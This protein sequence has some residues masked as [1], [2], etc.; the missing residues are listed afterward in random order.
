MIPTLGTGLLYR[1][2]RDKVQMLTAMERRKA[3][4]FCFGIA[5]CVT[6]S[7]LI[8]IIYK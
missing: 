6:V 5:V 1:V 8:W 7:V 2:N 3:F 4:M